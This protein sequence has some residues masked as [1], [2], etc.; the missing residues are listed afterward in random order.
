MNPAKRVCLIRF[1]PGDNPRT[2]KTV[3]AI[4]SAG[5][6]V[7]LICVQSET[8]ITRGA[9]N[10]KT[11]ETKFYKN[12]SIR[13]FNFLIRSFIYLLKNM[14]TYL[15]CS[16]EETCFPF[17][18]VFKPF[19][20]TIV[21]LDIYDSLG[22]RVQ[23]SVFIKYLCSFISD[24]SMSL[25]NLI[26]V[27]DDRRQ[28]NLKKQYQCK[29]IVVEN[30]P[31]FIPYNS[32]QAMP[33]GEIKIGLIG[34]LTKRRGID[35]AVKALS[36]TTNT[37]LVIAGILDEY[38]LSRILNNS[39]IDYHGVLSSRHAMDLLLECDASFSFYEPTT[40]NHIYASP[41]KI[42]DAMSVGR[43]VIVNSEAKVSSF[44][45][46]NKIG[47]TCSYY[48]IDGLINIFKKIKDERDNLHSFASETTSNFNKNYSWGIMSMR[49]L[50]EYSRLGKE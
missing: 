5:Y 47:F 1:G 23:G 35:I 7:H 4:S 15:H 19:R 36:K 12:S 16:N 13:Y 49:L 50:N 43:Y 6:E 10:C 46:K 11:F 42:F 33:S 9:A 26:I 20:K 44:I 27:C 29:S 21:I 14:P 22:D 48:D 2:V 38:S 34:N 25:S 37:R 24:V 39:K 18:L 32:K 17:L 30:S 31:I 3:E 40:K 45:I 28:A 41:S 8:K